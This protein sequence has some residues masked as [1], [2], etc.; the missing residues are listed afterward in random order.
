MDGTGSTAALTITGSSGDNTLIGGS[1]AETLHGGSGNDALNGGSGADYVYGDDGNDTIT[2][3]A[4]DILENGGNGIDTLKVVVGSAMMINLANADQADGVVSV[5]GFENVDGTGSTGA[6]TM[7]GD[8]NAN[9]L[10]GGSAADT[11]YASAGGDQ[12]YGGD[13]G[14]VFI[15]T[16]TDTMNDGEGGN[17]WLAV[18]QGSATVNLSNATDQVTSDSGQIT[19]NFENVDG[20]GNS[21]ALNLT[22]DANNNFIRGGIAADILDGGAGD[23][24]MCYDVADVHTYGGDGND[25][26]YINEAGSRPYRTSDVSVTANLGNATD[27]T[28]GGS[29]TT[30]FE[31]IDG[32]AS[33]AAL[34]L[35]GDAGANTLK[36]GSA[37]DVLDGVGGAD[38]VYGGGGTDTIFYDVSDAVTD[39]GAG[40]D[41]LYLRAGSGVATINL[42]ATNQVTPVSGTNAVT[43]FEY[44]YAVPMTTDVV[45][46]GDSNNN[47]LNMGSGNDTIDGAGGLD[48]LYGNDGNDRIVYDAADDTE[49]GGAGSDWLVVSRTSAL[50]INL[51]NTDHVA[52]DTANTKNFENV[53][54]NSSSGNM[55]I[56]GNSLDNYLNTGSGVDTLTGGLGNDT[57]IG[58]IGSDTYLFAR[59]D[60]A[61]SIYEYD[62]TGANTNILQFTTAV[63]YD[64]L[65]FKQIGNNLEVNV[66]GTNDKVTIGD[67]YLGSSQQVQSIQ[68]GGQELLNTSVANLVNAM[69]SLTPPAAG[70]T[71]LTTAQHTALDPVIAANWHAA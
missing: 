56:T 52:G 25:M 58:G 54:A 68:A 39:G 43:G 69:A 34:N 23:D 45:I 20:L 66:I 33:R 70:Q 64:Q 29:I 42:A 18:Q 35:T 36:G 46:T 10:R 53:D 13:G 65:W 24:A 9:I 22:G 26:L 30:G 8:A 19:K 40:V 48:F 2:Y 63:N 17:D 32:N 62:G 60:G 28:T 21:S 27:Q 37:N 57:L 1:A 14:D 15:Y 12:R 11:L 3:D 47:N 51:A 44:V 55:T 61:D 7:F 38:S 41:I 67:W 71:T 31:N 59:G 4:T 50:T 6:L 16:T 49:D 5:A